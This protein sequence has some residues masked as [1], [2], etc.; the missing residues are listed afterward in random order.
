MYQTV[1]F[2]CDDYPTLLNL[3][4]HDK[5]NTS[6]TINFTPSESPLHFADRRAESVIVGYYTSAEVPF[7]RRRQPGAPL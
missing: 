2:T 5:K 1:A 4:R 6:D 3:M 7:P